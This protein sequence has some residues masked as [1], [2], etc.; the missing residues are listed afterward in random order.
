[1]NSKG[2]LHQ[3][4]QPRT[5]ASSNRK[6]KS[7]YQNES[8][9]QGSLSQCTPQ[10]GT[11]CSLHPLPF[12]DG[13]VSPALAAL[14]FLTYIKTYRGAH[15]PICCHATIAGHVLHVCGFTCEWKHNTRVTGMPPCFPWIIAV[16]ECSHEMIDPAITGRTCSVEFSGGAWSRH[17]YCICWHFYFFFSRVGNWHINTR[18]LQGAYLCHVK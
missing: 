1:M 15:A 9:I 3:I 5:R 17:Y 18:P 13:L 12:P 10:T 7:H 16:L 2:R 4:L 8:N 11:G 14:H 6:K